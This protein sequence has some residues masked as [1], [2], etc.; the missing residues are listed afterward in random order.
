[1]RGPCAL[2]RALLLLRAR[3]VHTGVVFPPLIYVRAY[4]SLYA[5]GRTRIADRAMIRDHRS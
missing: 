2:P 1:M 4:A 5:R 3:Y